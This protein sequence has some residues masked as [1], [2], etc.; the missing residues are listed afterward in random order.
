MQ[1]DPELLVKQ[2]LAELDQ[3][4]HDHKEKKLHEE[5]EKRLEKERAENPVLNDKEKTTKKG[6]K[7]DPKEKE[8]QEKLEK[9]KAEQSKL[10][11]ETTLEH[12]ESALGNSYDMLEILESA[13]DKLE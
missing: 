2:K 1:N 8:K 10:E 13:E 9:E 4:I 6:A 12:L 11:E 5:E 3:R 7:V